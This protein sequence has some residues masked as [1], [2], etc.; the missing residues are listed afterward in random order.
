MGGES[1]WLK[2]NQNALFYP[3]DPIGQKEPVPSVRLKAFR[4][5]Q[6]DIEYL[7]ILAV[8]AKYSRNQLMTAVRQVLGIATEPS[9]KAMGL[10]PEARESLTPVDFWRLRTVIGKRLDSLHP[11]DRRRWVDLRTPARDPALWTQRRA[12]ELPS[13]RQGAD[14]ETTAGVSE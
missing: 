7:T 14:D 13:R 11:P 6:Q 10:G 3:G 9:G 1:A 8:Q 12:L 2:A 5:G 4:R